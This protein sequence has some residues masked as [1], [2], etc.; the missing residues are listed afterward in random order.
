MP[1]QPR[2]P[3]LHRC[4]QRTW[5]GRVPLA[6]AARYLEL[7]REVAIPDYRA[8][9]GNLGAA[10]ASHAEGEVVHVHMTSWWSDLDAV[11]RFAGEPVDAARYYD[12][13]DDFLLEKEASVVH[14]EW[15]GIVAMDQAASPADG[16]RDPVGPPAAGSASSPDD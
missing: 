13:D 6:K 11:R 8:T 2:T 7:M 5:H 15:H 14:A 1:A 9:E 16:G 3:A 12:F 4:V 10:C